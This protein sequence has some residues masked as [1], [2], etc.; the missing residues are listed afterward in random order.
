M[1]E[2]H[3]LVASLTGQANE[4]ATQARAPDL[5]SNPRP[6]GLLAYALTTDP[7][8]QVHLYIFIFRS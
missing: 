7:L 2:I 8:A 5:E 4:P 3:Q 1:R 6:F